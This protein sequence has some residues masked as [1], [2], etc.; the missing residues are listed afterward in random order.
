MDEEQSRLNEE[1]NS[2]DYNNVKENKNVIIDFIGLR[3]KHLLLTELQ[4]KAHVIRHSL[5]V[6]LFYL[7]RFL[8]YKEWFVID[9]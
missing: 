8:R 2:H 4:N 5:Y 9:F 6:G 1:N 3:M 7:I